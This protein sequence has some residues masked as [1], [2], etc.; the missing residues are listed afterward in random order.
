MTSD[1]YESSRNKNTRITPGLP[2]PDRFIGISVILTIAK[3]T[4]GSGLRRWLNTRSPVFVFPLIESRRTP[5][6]AEIRSVSIR[7]LFS[8][9]FHGPPVCAPLF[10][11]S[12]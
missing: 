7:K 6:R 1:Q 11:Q 10:L 12:Y 5:L 3:R 4:F 9:L 2:R 8:P